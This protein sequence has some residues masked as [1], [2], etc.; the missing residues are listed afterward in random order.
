MLYFNVNTIAF[1][2]MTPANDITAL[3]YWS[4]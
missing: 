3:C 1:H 4:F 2:E